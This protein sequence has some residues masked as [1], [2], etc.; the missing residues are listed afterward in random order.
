MRRFL[1]LLIVLIPLF[2]GCKGD[3]PWRDEHRG[4]LKSVAGYGRTMVVTFED[5]KSY[6]VELDSDLSDS[7]E[8]WRVGEEII[9]QTEV[10]CA[11]FYWRFKSVGVEIPGGAQS[12]PAEKPIRR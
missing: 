7:C 1:P 9:L 11:S 2:T 6:K 8:P 4:V 12:L 10:S 3:Y 5:D